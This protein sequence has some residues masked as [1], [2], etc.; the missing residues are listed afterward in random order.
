MNKCIPNFKKICLIFQDF[1]LCDLRK[2]ITLDPYFQLDE[3]AI[4][5]KT[6]LH[7][8]DDLCFLLVLPQWPI[9][10]LL[11]CHYFVYQRISFFYWHCFPCL[12]STKSLILSD[13]V[14]S[15]T[16]CFPQRLYQNMKQKNVLAGNKW[17]HM[18]ESG[19]ISNEKCSFPLLHLSIYFGSKCLHGIF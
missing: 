15:F 19:S 9:N 18:L 13:F 17:V 8:A 6:P 2:H 14:S 5:N 12:L 4:C 16:S 10:Y 1:Y 11:I 7:K 3:G